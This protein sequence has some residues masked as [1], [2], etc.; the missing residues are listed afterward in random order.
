MKW[1]RPSCVFLLL[2]VLMT[3]L[4]AG[5]VSR[6]GGDE[7]KLRDLAF[8][9][10]DR[11]EEPEELHAMIEKEKDRPFRIVYADQG[12]LYI[13]EGYGEQ[14]TTGY[15]V[16]VRKLYETDGT[17]CIHTELMGPE[18]GEDIREAATFPYVAVQ[19]EYIDKEVLF[20]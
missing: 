11:D 17:V 5:C 7:K 13:A 16:A 8:T 20:D 15:S 6:S 14:P 12:E 19:L 9:V 18:K 3:G 4:T 2:A 1:L 10:L